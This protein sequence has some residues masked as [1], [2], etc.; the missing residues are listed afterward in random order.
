MRSISGA[1]FEGDVA[2]DRIR[3]MSRKKTVIGLAMA[4]LAAAAAMMTLAHAKGGVELEATIEDHDVAESS[5]NQPVVLNPRGE[6]VLSVR[7]TNRGDRPVN[8]RTVRLEGV[9]I[10]L[11]FF[12]YDT[13]VGM[14]VR[15]GETEDRTF[16]MDLVGLEGQAVGLVR[17]KVSVLNKDRHTLAQV[18]MVVDVRGSLKSVYGVFGM[19]IAAFTFVALVGALVKLARHTLPMNR[20]RRAMRFATPGIGAGLTAVF[21][22]SALRIFSPVATKWL[23]LV[24][25]GA[26]IGF[27]LGYATPS[28]VGEEDEEEDDEEGEEEEETEP[29]ERKVAMPTMPTPERGS[30]SA[31]PTAGRGPEPT[32]VAPPPERPSGNDTEETAT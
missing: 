11:T 7:V 32:I 21:T 5:D 20:W 30:V 25:G 31:M 28:P 14:R 10:G 6:P 1:C 12:A 15:A 13:S 2:G 29:A 23:P 19:F 26:V 27:V 16:Q 4:A 22:L 24:L 17:G 3:R 9:A 18:P 8:I